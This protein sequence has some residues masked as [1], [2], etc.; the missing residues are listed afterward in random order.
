MNTHF[1]IH[2]PHYLLS[3]FIVDEFRF[4]VYQWVVYQHVISIYGWRIPKLII[5]YAFTVANSGEKS[6]TRVYVVTLVAVVKQSYMDLW[7]DFRIYWS[8]GFPKWRIPSRHHDNWMTI[9][10]WQPLRTVPCLK[11]S[12]KMGRLPSGKSLH[13]YGIFIYI[14]I[15][16]HGSF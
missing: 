16:I 7:I 3:L 8:V 4:I 13:S 12:E 5:Q 1:A 15:Y 14:Y 11:L 2:S 9:P 10:P 6:F